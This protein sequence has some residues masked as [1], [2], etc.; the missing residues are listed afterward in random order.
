MTA[1]YDF[2]VIGAG[3]SGAVVA[4]RLSEDRS[5]SVLLLEA[6][7]RDRHP[8]QLMPLAFPRVAMGRIGTWQFE[9]EPEPGLNGRRLAIPRGRTLGGTSSINAMIAIRGNR[10]DFD[11]WATQSLPGWSHAEVLPYFRRLE[12]HWRGAGPYHGGDGPVHISRMEGP[13]LL[14]EPLLAAAEAVGIPYCDDPNGAEQ[15]G[16]SR[17][18]LTVYK[19]NRVSSA[20]AYLYPARDRA[21]LTIETDAL[22][23]RIVVRGRRAIGVQYVRRGQLLTVIANEEVILSAGAYGSPQTLLLSGIGSVDELRAVGIDPVHDLP[24]VGRDLA[25]HPVVINEFDLNGDEGLTR[26]LRADRAALAAWQWFTGRR[27]LSPTPAR[28]RTSSRDRQKGSIGP[29]CR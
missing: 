1:G 14:W 28:S 22:V 7:P 8:L 19:G 29:T 27:G 4:A 18:E 26:H 3:S 13:E 16:V 11:D 9:S 24:G 15:D 5:V 23:Q 10:R 6:G 21:N 20:R 2:I 17:M 12:S 25:D